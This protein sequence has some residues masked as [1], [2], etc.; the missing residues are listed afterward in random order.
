[1]NWLSMTTKILCWLDGFSP[2]FAIVNAISRKT[3]YDLYGLI[4]V[5][6]ERKFYEKQKFIEFKKSWYIRDCFKK[7]L[8]NPDLDYLSKFEEKYKISLWKIAYS[9]INFTKYNKYYKFTPNQILSIFEQECS[10]FETV[11]DEVN[12]DFLI[13]RVTD[14]SD[15]QLLHLMC[16]ARGIKVLCLGFSRLGSRS[17]ISSELD[18][19]DLDVINKTDKEFSLTELESY[20]KEY[21]KQESFFR[22]HYKTS[23]FNW[24]K[25]AFQYIKM[26]SNP[27]YQTYYANYGKN[28]RN[29][30]KNE[31]SFL[32][33]KKIRGSFLEKHTKKDITQK[34]KFVYFPLQ[35]EPERTLFIP[36][37]YHTNQLEVIRNIARSLPVEYKLYVKEHPMQI[38]LGWRDTSFYKTI[39]DLPNVELIDTN[40][41][42]KTLIEKCSMIVTIVGTLGLEAAYYGKPSMVFSNTIFSELPS[43]YKL[44]DY[45][46]LPLAIRKSLKQQV[47]FDDVNSFINKIVNNSFDF[48]F[49]KTDVLFNNEFY[50]GGFL[51]DHYT[52]I[53]KVEKF[54]D[55]HK[56]LFEKLADEHIKKIN[57][58]QN[59]ILTK[60]HI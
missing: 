48:D 59:Y 60:N 13:I 27:K 57:Q 26:I 25:G 30:I 14:S 17:I 7:T 37:P 1:M 38:V 56:E 46:E 9:D 36:A 15:S 40:F 43:V 58:Y 23:R 29:V 11:L 6:E 53:D 8:D 20:S 16:K 41:P 24:V 39:I 45:E 51:F 49:E 54:L 42:N 55:K 31:V 18:T 21:V 3:D 35:L 34:E 50:Y 28:I 12:P 19:L 4:N 22:E 32:F 47:N 33:K 5:N 10:F 44:T 2:H 52:P